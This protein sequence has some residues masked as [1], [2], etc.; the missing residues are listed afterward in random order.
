MRKLLLL[1]AGLLA[2]SLPTH[3][4]ES[5]EI[6]SYDTFSNSTS[7]GYNI[8]RTYTSQ[9]SGLSYEM[10]A[11]LSTAASTKNYFQQNKSKGSYFYVTANT[12]NVIIKKVEL[13]N[14]NKDAT[15][16][17]G[18]FN[19][20]SSDDAMTLSLS[21]KGSGTAS[22]SGGSA[23]SMSSSAWEPNSKYFAYA[24][25][26]KAASFTFASIK[27]TYEVVNDNAVATPSIAM[28]EGDYGF[29]VE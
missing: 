11:Y 14:S 6:L 9:T 17:A 28:V 3:A 27:V 29:T 22:F 26:T 7:G 2:L 23:V 20:Y 21:S 15:T 24:V 18:Y 13:V 1:F 12:E 10:A 16:L 25:N 8:T 19:A 5:Y 4:E